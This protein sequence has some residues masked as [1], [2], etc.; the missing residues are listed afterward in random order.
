M[1]AYTIPPLMIFAKEGGGYARPIRSW[2]AACWLLS[3]PIG[4]TA[5]T[6][7]THAF[8]CLSSNISSPAWLTCEGDIILNIPRSICPRL[9]LCPRP[10][11]RA[12]DPLPTRP[13]WHASHLLRTWGI[14]GQFFLRR[15]CCSGLPILLFYIYLFL[16]RARAVDGF[17][18]PMPARPLLA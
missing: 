9:I 16:I 15:C 2:R 17:P 12:G 8:L 18:P 14:I 10:L 7:S 1:F 13:P 5:L 11:V 3:A 6:T 4:V